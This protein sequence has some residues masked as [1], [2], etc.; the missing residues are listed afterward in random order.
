MGTETGWMA[1]TACGIAVPGC[2]IRD[3]VSGPGVSPGEQMVFYYAN[4]LRAQGFNEQ[5][6]AEASDTRRKL[7][8]LLSTSF[9]APITS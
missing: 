3:A 2:G 9:Q 5:E 1:G 8:H 4:Q 6:V 7:W